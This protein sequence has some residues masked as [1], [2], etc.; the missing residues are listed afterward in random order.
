MAHSD[1]VLKIPSQPLLVLEM[2]LFSKSITP[3]YNFSQKRDKQYNTHKRIV[4]FHNL[5]FQVFT[6]GNRKTVDNVKV[7]TVGCEKEVAI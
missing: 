3:Y 6:K 1:T 7:I 5:T 2:N 4:Y